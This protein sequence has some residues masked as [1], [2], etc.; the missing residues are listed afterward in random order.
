MQE[1][2]NNFLSQKVG[3]IAEIRDEKQKVY[4][5]KLLEENIER[6]DSGNWEVIEIHKFSVQIVTGVKYYIKG[7]FMDKNY[8]IF[9]DATV[10]ILQ[11]P[12]KSIIDSMS[13]LC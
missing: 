2:V 7:I 4:V 5:K 3:G 13:G 10:S 8:N 6:L 11:I 1:L 12:W 9:Y